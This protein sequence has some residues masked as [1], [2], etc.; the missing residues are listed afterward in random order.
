MMKLQPKLNIDQLAAI[1]MYNHG[2]MIFPAPAA[3]KSKIIELVDYN[4]DGKI[5]IG[6][7]R[8]ALKAVDLHF[9]TWKAVFAKMR[10]DLDGDG[11]ISGDEI[12]QLN[13]Y[14]IKKWGI[15]MINSP[16][17]DA[18]IRIDAVRKI[19][20]VDYD[21]NGKISIGELRRALKAAGLHFATFKAVV[22]TVRVDLDGDGYISGDEIKKLNQ[23]AIKHWGISVDLKIK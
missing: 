7:L 12:K 2:D 23:Y 8:K 21:G 16:G 6:E 14:A 11:Y 13:A 10:V 15:P 18:Y 19:E 1:L 9:T 5:S 4:N 20:L 3:E 22:A 17:P